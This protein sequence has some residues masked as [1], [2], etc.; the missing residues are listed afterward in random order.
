[1]D[2]LKKIEDFKSKKKYVR[3]TRGRGDF[4]ETDRGY[5]VGYSS[6][7][8]LLQTTDDFT[9]NGYSIFPLDTIMELRHNKHDRF[10]DKIM[11]LEN[12]KE[13]IG[14]PYNLDL[15]SWKSLFQSLKKTEL[16]VTI[17]CEEPHLDYFCIGTLKQVGERQVSMLYFSPDGILDNTP[18]VTK[19]VDVTRV[20]FD[21]RYANIMSKYVEPKK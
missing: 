19:Y 8:I 14:I 17:K 7:F 21:D 16:T 20:E 2:T 11:K 9:F 1:M 6:V 18:T 3:L 15:T 13:N 4:Q 12:Q 5:I 10:Y